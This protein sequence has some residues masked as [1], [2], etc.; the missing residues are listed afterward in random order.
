MTISMSANEVM[1][2]IEIATIV[3]SIVALV[4][5]AWV[6]YLLVRPPRHKRDAVQ[7]EADALDREEMLASMDRMERRLETLERL[8][9]HDDQP[10]R[11]APR[12]ADE[13]SEAVEDRAL[14]R[15]K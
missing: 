12:A 2:A 5:G 13:V 4:I 14:G 10:A 7:P 15:T 11:I 3:G 1:E 8:V 6:I 9:T